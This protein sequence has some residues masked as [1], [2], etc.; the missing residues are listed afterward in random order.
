[1]LKQGESK[2]I[3]EL[4]EIPGILIAQ[5]RAHE[6]LLIDIA[7]KVQDKTPV[8]CGMG[9]SYFLSEFGVFFLKHIAGVPNAY[10]VEGDELINQIPDL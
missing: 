7:A 3:Q 5:N 4:R 9:S 8:M 6:S 10:C 2:M 1:M